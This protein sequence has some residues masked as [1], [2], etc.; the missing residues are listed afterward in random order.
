MPKRAKADELTGGSKDV[1]PQWFTMQV[2]QTVADVNTTAQ[3]PLPVQRLAQKDGKA[4]VFEI[5]KIWSDGPFLLVNNG[6]FIFLGAYLTTKNPNVAGVV[7]ITVPQEFQLKGNGSTIWYV[8]KETG[9]HAAGTAST[10]LTI[11]PDQFDLSDAAGHGV[12][13]AT[14]QVFLTVISQLTGSSNVTGALNGFTIKCLYR[15]K[16]IT[17]PEYI[18]IVQSQQ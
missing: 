1:N 11:E 10:V 14:D 2:Q 4:L 17:L 6:T 5:L 18:S 15:W 7:G 3:I 16:E 12:L 8:N 9:V 13:V